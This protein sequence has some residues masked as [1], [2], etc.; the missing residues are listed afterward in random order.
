MQSENLANVPKISLSF[1]DLKLLA[2]I[3]RSY[4]RCLQQEGRLDE[5]PDT[6]TRRVME[7]RQR[8][9]SAA[10]LSQ[11]DSMVYLPMTMNEIKALRKGIRGFMHYVSRRTV[12]TQERTESLADLERLCGELTAMIFKERN[13][14]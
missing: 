14:L 13:G 5:K 10:L 2:Q 11:T 3:L 4:L 7:M 1:N 8:I 12:S 9:E 6:Q